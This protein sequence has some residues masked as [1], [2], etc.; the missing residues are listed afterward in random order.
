[1]IKK[2][3]LFFEKPNYT[4]DVEL[5][6]LIDHSIILIRALVKHEVRT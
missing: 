5:I 1:M 3:I 6:L 2:I 4:L